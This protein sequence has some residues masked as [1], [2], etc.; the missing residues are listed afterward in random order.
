VEALIIVA[1]VA[2]I[3]GGAYLSYYLKKKRRQELALAAKQFGF[4]YSDTDP[5]SLVSLPFHLLTLGDG[6][7]TE[8]VMWGSWQGTDLKEF[9]YWYYT[10]S[11]DS[12]GNTTRSYHRFSCA[13]TDLP[14]HCAHLTLQREG[15][16]TRMADH[17]GFHDIEFESEEFNRSFQ[18]TCPDRKFANDVIDSRM[19]QW[20]LSAQ[21]RWGYELSSNH[22]LCYSKRLR[23]IELTPL[24]GGLKEFRDHIPRVAWSLYGT[25]AAANLPPAPEQKGFLP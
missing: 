6:R 23:P 1:V 9:D 13:V 17:L 3:A 2:F 4:Q 16:F 10:E 25:G 24:L 15:F 5:F 7:G 8:N 11:T 18:V 12:K 22:L 14:M 21:E 20:L 19:M